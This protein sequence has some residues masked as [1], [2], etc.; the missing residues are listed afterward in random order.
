MSNS[1]RHSN[2]FFSTPLAKGLYI[3]YI[4]RGGRRVGRGFFAGAMKYF[5]QLLIGHETFLKIFDELS[6]NFSCASFLILFIY[7]FFLSSFFK[8][9][10]RVWAQNV[11]TSH[12]RDFKNEAI[13]KISKI[14][15]VMWQ[16]LVKIKNNFFDVSWP[17]CCGL[18][19]LWGKGYL[20]LWRIFLRI[21]YLFD[22]ISSISLDW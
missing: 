1:L 20:L 16:M 15:L 21:L 9:V 18:S 14:H 3:K 7:L 5:R 10:M 13:L 4:N 17:C 22:S 19:S 6:K 8:D 11:Q 12:Q 2:F